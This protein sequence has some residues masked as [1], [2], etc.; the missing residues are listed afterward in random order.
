MT[1]EKPVNLPSRPGVY[2]LYDKGGNV[3]YVGKAGNLKDRLAFYFQKSPVPH[4]R[5]E[6]L[7]KNIREVDYLVTDNEVEA[8]LLETNLIKKYKPRFNVRLKDDKR[9]PL[10]EITCGDEIPKLKIVRRPE[11]PDSRYFGPYTDVSKMRLLFRLV[12]KLFGIATCKEKT[13]LR[14]T[15][16]CLDYQLGQCSAPC[17]GEIDPESYR[18][19]VR[20]A[21]Y[22]LD[23]HLAHLQKDLKKKLEDEA[24]KLNFEECARIQKQLEALSRLNESQKVFFPKG[25]DADYLALFED[26]G[27]TSTIELL[28]VREG[29]LTGHAHFNLTFPRNSSKEEKLT[30]FINLHYNPCQKPPHKIYLPF[31]LPE[32]DLLS[33]A[34]SKHAGYRVSLITPKR[35]RH[36]ELIELARKNA[37]IRLASRKPNRSESALFSLSEIL[38]LPAPPERI[39]GYDISHLGGSEPVGSMV[40]F[41]NG[42]ADKP[43]YRLFNL[44]LEKTRNDPAM[45]KEI[46]TRRFSHEEWDLPDLILLDGGK[47][48]LYAGLNA[49]GNRHIP[50]ISLAK[51]NELVYLPGKKSPLR[52]K[53][54]HPA[55]Q[56]LKQIR[57]ESHRFAVKSQRRRRKKSRLKSILREIPGLGKV[58]TEKLLSTY[59]SIEEIKTASEDELASIG[60]FGIKIAGR[61]KDML[62]SKRE[63]S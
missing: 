14:R 41:I 11:N 25:G 17:T 34:L 35:G 8:L 7:I 31:S 55:L 20:Q 61:I 38:K 2:L 47:S 60:D 62:K 59:G 1:V 24:K 10:L 13:Y 19:N 18:E 43:S 12:R 57:D 39:E 9:Y 58:R 49:L 40:V 26:P 44:K 54:D 21:I 27:V 3:I 36:R 6:N 48:Q 52:L 42:K 56:L 51:E 16:P 63:K 53:H 5:L 45:M 33:E 23:G 37:L 4:P 50:I 46:L 30:A 28:R 32:T 15:R 22:M 29:K